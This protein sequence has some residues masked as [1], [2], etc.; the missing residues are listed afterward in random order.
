MS[1]PCYSA[2]PS[3][4]KLHWLGNCQML[5][6]VFVWLPLSV[7][8]EWGV[9]PVLDRWTSCRGLGAKAMARPAVGHTT[10]PSTG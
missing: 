2:N 5:G 8:D 1:A 3:L 7:Y 6:P 9:I 10:R 4:P